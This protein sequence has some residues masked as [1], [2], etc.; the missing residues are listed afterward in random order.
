MPQAIGYMIFL[1]CLMTVIGIFDISQVL[2][3]IER[4]LR[5]T[6]PDGTVEEPER[7]SKTVEFRKSRKE[8]DPDLPKGEAAHISKIRFTGRTPL[9]RPVRKYDIEE[10]G[11]DALR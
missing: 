2:R 7:P 1:L 3:R 6:E 4:R 10:D 5:D 9:R 8:F 11:G